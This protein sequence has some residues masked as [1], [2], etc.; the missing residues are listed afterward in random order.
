MPRSRPLVD[1]PRRP[2][3]HRSPPLIA[4]AAVACLLSGPALG[5]RSDQFDAGVTYQTIDHFAAH[6]SWTGQVYGAW[7]PARRAAISD[8][9]FDRESGIGLSGWYYHLGAGTDATIAA[10]SYPWRLRTQESFQVAP[11]PSNSSPA[12]WRTS[13]STS[14]IIPTRPSGSSST[15]SAPSTS[16]STTGAAAARRATAGSAPRRSATATSRRWRPPSMPAASPPA[17][18]RR[19]RP[20]SSRSPAARTT[21]ATS[22]AT[23]RS[24]AASATC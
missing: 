2:A 13:S 11:G 9:L 6:D 14:G 5:Q 23:P 3:A 16:R 8:A 4:S 19:N 10:R 22:P 7:S 1:G 18:G 20:R 21:S 15:T 17:S 12:T 24:A